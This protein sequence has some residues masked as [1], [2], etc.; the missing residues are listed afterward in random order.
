MFSR[1]YNLSDVSIDAPYVAVKILGLLPG[2]SNPALKFLF[3]ALAL[4]I[5]AWGF[6]RYRS[7]FSRAEFLIAIVFSAGI[8]SVGVFPGIYEN[9][10]TLLNVED[11]LVVLLIANTGFVFL[12][13]YLITLI[14]ANQLSI[15]ELTRSL[16]RDQL[17]VDVF[18]EPTILVINPAY[19]EESTVAGVVDSL[20][21]CIL[22]YDVVPLVV[23]DG[24]GDA[25]VNRAQAAGAYVVE[26]SINQ[27]QG[28]ALKTGFEIAQQVGAE[29]VVTMDA[30]GQHP[31]DELPAIVKPIIENEADYVVGSR[32]LGRDLSNNNLVRR[33]GIRV[34]TALIN[35]VSKANITDC[36]NGYRA[37][38][39]SELAKMTLTEEKFSA[40]ELLIE[41]RKN[42]LRIHEIP[43]TVKERES[44]E[45]KK[46]Q[47]KYGLGLLRTIFMTWIR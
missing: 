42:G 23:S 45:T 38:R 4:V 12:I 21:D 41:A 26:H 32:Y 46:P 19:N 6:E 43:I 33:I 28:G 1:A 13:L 39:V 20:P 2:R 44:G 25:T 7:N 27:G 22:G 36:T 8:L 17:S 10:G 3:F 16:A 11:R 31:A 15:G 9:I 34:F 14:R 24:S 18:D 35:F 40:P 5:F 47:I 30:D 37:I 29:I